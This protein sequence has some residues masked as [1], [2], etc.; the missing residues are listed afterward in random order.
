VGRQ[1]LSVV[2]RQAKAALTSEG[3]VL[4]YLIE[5]N[6]AGVDICQAHSNNVKLES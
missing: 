5:Q 6:S 2:I 1:E 3:P 4:W